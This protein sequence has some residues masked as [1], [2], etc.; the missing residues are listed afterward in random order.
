MQRFGLFAGAGDDAD[1]RCGRNVDLPLTPALSPGERESP[2]LRNGKLDAHR[3][4]R[5]R[6]MFLPR[7]GG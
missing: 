1:A 5:P 2:R 4:S 6:H 7:P 3:F